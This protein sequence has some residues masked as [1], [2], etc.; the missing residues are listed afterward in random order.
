[1]ETGLNIYD[2]GLEHEYGPLY[3]AY[4]QATDDGEKASLRQQWIEAGG[5]QT[6]RVFVGKTRGKSSAVILADA[7]GRPKIM[8][9]VDPEGRPVLNFL[10]D[11]GN[12][13]QSLPESSV[14]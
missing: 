8:M 2:R 7:Q 11:N 3:Q 10:D 1:M 14:Q 12:V 4:L 6:K 5:R 9:L 13:V